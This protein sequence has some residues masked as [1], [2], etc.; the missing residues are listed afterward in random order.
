MLVLSTKPRFDTPPPTRVGAIVLGGLSAVNS[1]SWRD[2][3]LSSQR[4]VQIGSSAITRHG[5]G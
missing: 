1:F 3:E 5:R 2:C 4:S